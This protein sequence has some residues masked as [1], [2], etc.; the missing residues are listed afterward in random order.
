[1]IAVIMSVYNSDNHHHLSEALISLKTQ[2][3]TN[4]DIYLQ[5]DGPVNKNISE[6]I[7][8][9]SGK[10]F[11]PEYI[12][13]QHGLAWQLNRAIERVK[14]S[15]KC[16]K[17]LARMDADDISLPERFSE[18]IEFFKNNENVSIIGTDIIEFDG[19]TEFYK[20]MESEHNI[21][22]NNI[23]LKC[24]LNHPTVMFDLF[25]LDIKDLSYKSNLKN[26]QDYYLWIDLLSKGY[27]ISNVNKPLLRFRIND[28]FYRRRG[29]GKAINDIKSRCYAMKKLSKFSIK[30][31]IYIFLLFMLRISPGRVKKI[32]YQMFR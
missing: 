19:N 26:T 18:Q 2:T 28:N 4:L 14:V 8:L 5:V 10:N 3:Y 7:R 20:K 24:P 15:G 6:V 23:I 31:I 9:N 30:N 25:R 32:L 21:I 11:F 29:F 16:Y 12:D 1:M 17:Y 27:I 13:K 22:F